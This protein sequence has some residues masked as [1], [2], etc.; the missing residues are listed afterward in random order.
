MNVRVPDGVVF[1]QFT[2]TGC[3]RVFEVFGAYR[4]FPSGDGFFFD[5][6]NHSQMCAD[7]A[8]HISKHANEGV[9]ARV[10]PLRPALEV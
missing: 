7:F 9:H 8:S 3:V 10:V 5:A 1:A 6:L 4:T 2:C